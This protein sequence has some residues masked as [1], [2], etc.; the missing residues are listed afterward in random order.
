MRN[1]FIGFIISLLF[2][3]H[4]PIFN[5]SSLHLFQIYTYLKQRKTNL[6]IQKR[7]LHILGTSICLSFIEYGILKY[8]N[9]RFIL[10]SKI[11]VLILGLSTILIQYKF[12]LNENLLV[13]SIYIL[14]HNIYLNTLLS[15]IIFLYQLFNYNLEMICRK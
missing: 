2:M 14:G 11:G 7:L 15:L 12:D 8:M 4:D 3:Q 13:L 6:T 10:I 1:F 5:I 9:I